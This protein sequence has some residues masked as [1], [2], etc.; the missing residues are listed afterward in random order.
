M[1]RPRGIYPAAAALALFFALRFSR[2]GPAVEGA[3]ADRAPAAGLAFRLENHPTAE[4]YLIETMTGGCA[5]LDYDADGRLDIFLVNGAAIVAGAGGQPPG[6]DKTHPKYWNRLYRNTGNGRFVDATERAGARG[7]GYGMGVAAGDY[8]NDGYPD[9]YVTNYGRNQLLRNRGDGTFQDVTG[10]AGAGGGGFSTSAAFFDYDRDGWLDLFVA[11]YVN[12]S[13]QNHIVCGLG[14]R[15]DYCH[16]K[17]FEG[18]RNLLFRNNRDGTFRDVSQETGIA[19]GGGKSLGV[20]IEDLDRDGWPDIYVANDS[21]P[22]FLFHNQAGRGFREIGLESGSALNENGSAFAGMGADFADYD[23]DGWPDLFVTALSLEGFVLYRNQRDSTF[24]DVSQSAGVKK[25]SFYL[26][27]WGTRFVDFDNDGW[28]DL[29]VANSHVMRDIEH[30]IRTLSYL[31]PLLMLHNRRGAFEDA[32]ARLGP[33]FAQKFAARGAAFG[34]YDNDGDL[35]ILVQVLGAQPLLLENVA[36]SR[37]RWIG[38]ELAGSAGN[39]DA[40]G[41]VI[42]A[43]GQR[44][45]VSRASSYLSSNDPRVIVGLGGG[46]AEEIEITWPSGRTQKLKP[47]ANRY[48]KIVEPG[49]PANPA[50]GVSGPP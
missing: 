4:K 37:N 27:G 20:A 38:L 16:P 47:A 10:R 5:F 28:K 26:S 49:T 40:I 44:H 8:D 3:F 23:N 36:G 1:R 42:R 9:L 43:G 11:R 17:H 31:Q 13:F 50:S 46:P 24:S 39:R 29:F 45:F 41:A 25:A 21:V 6:F 18:E 2:A 12:W 7:A 22:G 19:L 32:G 14:G 30:S 34:D 33:V 15:R 48:T 35:D